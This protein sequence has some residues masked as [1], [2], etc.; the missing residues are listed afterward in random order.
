MRVKSIVGL[1]LISLAAVL[2]ACG[3]KYADAEKV[4]TEFADAMDVYLADLDKAKDADATA[5]AINEFTDVMEDLAPRMQEINAKYPELKD[6]ENVPEELKPIK[7]R[8]DKTAMQMAGTFMKAM[9]HM[10]NPEVNAAFTRLG[11]VMTGIGKK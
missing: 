8:S 3:G 9:Q 1:M 2:V 6:P 11:K 5:A 7:E 4:Y 10:K